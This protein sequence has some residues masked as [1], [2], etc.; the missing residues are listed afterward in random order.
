MALD[1]RGTSRCL[2]EYRSCLAVFLLSA[3]TLLV[4]AV[5]ST[6][7]S[8]AGAYLCSTFLNGLFIGALMNYSLSHLLHLTPPEVHYVVTALVGMAR[9][10]AGSFGSAMGGGFFQRGLKES[11]ERGF[12]VHDIPNKEELI[13]KLLGSPALVKTLSGVERAIAVQSYEHAVKTL[14]LGSCV[15]GLVATVIQAGTGWTSYADRE[16]RFQ[17]DVEGSVDRET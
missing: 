5:L 8:P 16:K 17:G 12:S 6:P 4:L 2:T 7:S 15:L 11:L 3:L 10:F 1:T 14:L 13:R 9:G